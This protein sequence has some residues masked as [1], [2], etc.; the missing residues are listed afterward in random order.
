MCKTNYE[1]MPINWFEALRCQTDKNVLSTLLP[2]AVER[3]HIRFLTVWRRSS[4]LVRVS[5]NTTWKDPDDIF[6][7]K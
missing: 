4:G 7:I 5:T 1:Q 2:N 6:D 3:F